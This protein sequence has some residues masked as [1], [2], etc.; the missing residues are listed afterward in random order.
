[1]SGPLSR[2]TPALVAVAAFSLANNLLMLTVSIYMMQVFDRVLT[3]QNLATLFYLTLMAFGALSVVGVLELVRSRILLRVGNWLD[4]SMTFSVLARSLENA[5]RGDAYRSE[6]LRDLTAIRTYLSGGG[7]LSL[8]D[9]PWVPVYIAFVYVLNPWLGHVALAG[10]VL[11]LTCATLN[12]FLTATALKQASAEHRKGFARVEAAFRNAEVIDSMAMTPA[13]AIAWQDVNSGVLSMQQ[14]AGDR[15]TLL[16]SMSKFLRLIVQV[17]VLATG[18]VLVLWHELSAGGMI[19][20]SIILSRALA[21][22]E[23]SIGTW[24]QTVMARESWQRLRRLLAQPPLHREGMPL[25]RP[26]GHLTVEGV[27]YTP[28]GS[29]APILHRISLEARPGEVLAIIG[30]SAAGKSMLARLIVGISKPDS[31]TVRLDGADIFDIDRRNFGNIVG[32]LPQD[33]EL[34]PGTIRQNIA[35]MQQGHPGKVVAAAELAGV[36]DMI[37]RMP[38]GYETE[39][40]EGGAKLSGGQRQRI[41]LARAAYG[42]PVLVVLDEPNASLDA[43]G[44]QALA[45]AIWALKSAG[46]T[47]VL[48]AHR[49]ALLAKVDN[50]AILNQ[51]RLQ[52]MGPRD[53][54]LRYLKGPAP[55]PPARGAPAGV[56][57]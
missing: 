56:P 20:A 23:Q 21:P 43:A 51:G 25:R 41:A 36:H 12:H 26:T 50:V 46:A 15:A 5:V 28:P 42:D 34:F 37:L 35:R 31:G 4:Q 29:P 22:V 1:M 33:V 16:T 30:P 9:V 32:Y 55:Q 7:V 3:S 39:I 47:V 52:F 10:A 27:T 57:R 2:A 11:L 48:I 45:S 40:G 49:P 14:N 13:L 17:A 6:A 18:A 8:F 53:D 38:N 24:K 54:A 44:D 19:A